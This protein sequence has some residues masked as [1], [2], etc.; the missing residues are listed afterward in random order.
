MP[1]LAAIALKSLATPGREGEPPQSLV[2]E[3]EGVPVLA[4]DEH[5]VVGR[6]S[7]KC[8]FRLWWFNRLTQ[9]VTTTVLFGRR[10]EEHGHSTKRVDLATS[11][12]KV[13]ML[14]GITHRWFFRSAGSGA[15]AIGDFVALACCRDYQTGMDLS[16][17]WAPA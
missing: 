14:Q 1:Y 17:N 8:G 7:V 10:R 4:N 15:Y 16:R 2:P 6:V 9:G 11:C 12:G 5:L 13:A 3:L